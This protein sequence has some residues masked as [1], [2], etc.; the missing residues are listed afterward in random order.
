MKSDGMLEG[1]TQTFRSGT[2]GWQGSV[3]QGNTIERAYVPP[4][5]PRFLVTFILTHEESDTYTGAAYMP[6]RGVNLVEARGTLKECL[7]VFRGKDISNM[8]LRSERVAMLEQ[9][10][11]GSTDPGLRCAHMALVAQ[12][13]KELEN[14]IRPILA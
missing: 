3:S 8:L 5:A 10:R 9:L 14:A 4:S 11:A 7:A 1:I 12:A 13:F 6:Y 2:P